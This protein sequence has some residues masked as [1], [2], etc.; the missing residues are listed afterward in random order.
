MH[1]PFASHHTDKLWFVHWAPTSNLRPSESLRQGSNHSLSE[2]VAPLEGGRHNHSQI[3]GLLTH[4][5][6]TWCSTSR[7]FT[8]G[9]LKFPAFNF[10]TLIVLLFRYHYPAE[11]HLAEGHSLEAILQLIYGMENINY[12]NYLVVYNNTK[13]FS[14]LTLPKSYLILNPWSYDTLD[15]RILQIHH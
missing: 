8:K 13:K 10:R 9:R 5:H 14:N 6:L 2:G 1:F 11:K 3:I 15:L 4:S 7:K 12:L